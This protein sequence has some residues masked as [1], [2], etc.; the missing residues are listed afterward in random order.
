MYFFN[1]EECPF[2]TCYLNI[3]I[4]IETVEGEVVPLLDYPIITCICYRRLEVNTCIELEGTI[5]TN[6]V[7]CFNSESIVTLTLYGSDENFTLLTNSETTINGLS[8]HELV[9]TISVLQQKI[10]FIQHQETILII[11]YSALAT[12]YQTYVERFDE[13]VTTLSFT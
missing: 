2:I 6:H 10:I 13:S 5:V 11:V 8:A 1:I 7:I 4:W 3:V 9:Y 12:S